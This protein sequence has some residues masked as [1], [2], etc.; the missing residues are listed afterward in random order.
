MSNRT[1]RLCAIV[2]VCMTAIS[3]GAQ[4]TRA[5]FVATSSTSQCPA[6]D[7]VLKGTKGALADAQ[8]APTRTIVQQ[9]LGTEHGIK[10]VLAALIAITHDADQATRDALD[11]V[12]ADRGLGSLGAYAAEI[13]HYVDGSGR[14]TQPHRGPVDAL[15]AAML[16][17][18]AAA[19][20]TSAARLLSLEVVLQPDHSRTLVARG[21]GDKPWLSD[22]VDVA[23][24]ALA[25]AEVR[26]AFS[27]IEFSD[28]SSDDAA[29]QTINVG[30]EA[31][32]L[33]VHLVAQDIAAPN[34]DAQYTRSVIDGVLLPRLTT[35]PAQDAVRALLQVVMLPMQAD[36]EAFASIKQMLT[37]ID[38]NDAHRDIAAM[39]YDWLTIQGLGAFGFVND[40]AAV[41]NDAAI[42]EIRPLAIDLAV[43]LAKHPGLADD[44]MRVLARFIA[45]EHAPTVVRTALALRGRGLVSELF[46]FVDAL[47]VC[48]P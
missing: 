40:V 31:L 29:D 39:V 8:F 44:V 15:H 37:C 10:V 4:G 16:D 30:R 17:C 41:A 45:P 20:L 33:L 38:D 3:C 36:D 22:V 35:P 18:A 5:P 25:I 27:T 14:Y 7:D 32:Q 9:V 26:E 24:A 28:A 34:F 12:P 21:A 48:F 6:A 47:G 1:A 13:L 23:Q 19:T 11:A 42:P 2:C 46:G 43:S